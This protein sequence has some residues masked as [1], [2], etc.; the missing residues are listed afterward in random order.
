M[1]LHTSRL[2]QVQGR[3]WRLG[4]QSG[5][6]NLQSASSGLGKGWHVGVRGPSPRSGEW[7]F[8]PTYLWAVPT[9]SLN[10][11]VLK[12]PLSILM[13]SL[14]LSPLASVPP[15]SSTSGHLH[16]AQGH[17]PSPCH[18]QHCPHLPQAFRI[19][20]TGSTIHPAI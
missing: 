12:L 6:Q 8:S 1:G 10:L 15:M 9:C 3:E 5:N 19:A 17:G 4:R 11:R 13:G 20:A 7:R 16:P 2:P 18:G 14:H